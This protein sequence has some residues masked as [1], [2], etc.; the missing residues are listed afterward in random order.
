MKNNKLTPT[1]PTKD[2]NDIDW[3]H[4]CSACGTHLMTESGM[5]TC[6]SAVHGEVDSDYCKELQKNINETIEE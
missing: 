4:T 1:F 6:M 5:F 2:F 3:T